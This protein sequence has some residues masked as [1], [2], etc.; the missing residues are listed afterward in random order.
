[1][2]VE[3]TLEELS[4]VFDKI[5]TDGDG[6]LNRK[7]IANLLRR[8]NIEPTR[9]YIDTIFSEIDADNSGLISRSEFFKYMTSCPPSR[10]IMDELASQFRVFDQDGDGIITLSELES[11][12]QETTDLDDKAAIKVMFEATDTDNDGKITFQEFV[13]MMKE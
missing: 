12:L 10:T 4:K 8:A 13:A 11:V 7:E 5:D 1:M 9:L 2:A 6:K 3:F